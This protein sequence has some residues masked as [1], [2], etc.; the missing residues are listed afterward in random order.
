MPNPFFGP[1]LTSV[2]VRTIE[3]TELQQMLASGDP[4]FRL[5]MG[6]GEWEFR[7]KHIPGSMHFNTAAEMLAALRKDD[8]IVVYCTNPACLASI[9]MYQRLV[10]EGYA[11]VRRYAG[12]VEDWEA[13]GLTLEHS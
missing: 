6:L 13:A 3:R 2:P 9:S 10:S 4:R 1:V 11:N 7:A 12:G 5:V 8:E